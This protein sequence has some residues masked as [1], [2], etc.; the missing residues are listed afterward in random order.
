MKQNLKEAM[1]SQLED[2]DQR[3]ETEVKFALTWYIYSSLCSLLRVNTE[4]IDECEFFLNAKCELTW[5][6]VFRPV[7]SP[8]IKSFVYNKILIINQGC[9]II[10]SNVEFF[11]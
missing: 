2:S 5:V 11:V 7:L 9:L 3:S 6:R 8:C 10:Y 4:K 1:D